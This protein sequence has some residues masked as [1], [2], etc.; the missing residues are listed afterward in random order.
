MIAYV[1]IEP[2]VFLSYSHSDKKIAEGVIVGLKR[3]MCRGILR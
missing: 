1:G 2:F 3:K